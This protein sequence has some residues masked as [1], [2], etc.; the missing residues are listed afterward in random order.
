MI[1]LPPYLFKFPKANKL[2]GTLV[3]LRSFRSVLCKLTSV[4]QEGCSANLNDA[5]V[6]GGSSELSVFSFHQLAADSKR[7]TTVTA[8]SN[9][10]KEH[11]HRRLGHS[12]SYAYTSNATDS[13]SDSRHLVQCQLWARLLQVEINTCQCPLCA[14][15]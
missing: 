8:S 14:R 1:H 9:L 11:V 6:D 15:H 2:P 3:S 7:P 12:H 10:T 4:I 5:E 13:F